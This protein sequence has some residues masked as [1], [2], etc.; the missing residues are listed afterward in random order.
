MKESLTTTTSTG[1]EGIY[2]EYY[3]NK[4]QKE[5]KL[6]FVSERY[7]LKW[8]PGASP[9]LKYLSDFSLWRNLSDYIDS[10]WYSSID[11]SFLKR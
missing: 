8:L 9:Q 1:N 6:D 2:N 7:S 3:L 5:S 11:W 10:W 4:Y